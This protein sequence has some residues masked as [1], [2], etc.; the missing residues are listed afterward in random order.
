[1]R[2]GHFLHAKG[3]DEACAHEQDGA[4]EEGGQIADSLREADAQGGTNRLGD[5][6]GDAVDADAAAYSGRGKV[7][8][9]Q[10]HPQWG[11]APHADAM[12]E[13]QDDENGE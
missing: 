10:R 12:N 8:A 6:L 2:I 4:N 11:G 9:G 7:V 1:M 3:D 5:G 13:A